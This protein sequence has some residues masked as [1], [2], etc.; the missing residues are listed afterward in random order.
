MHGLT[1]KIL[2]LYEH[3]LSYSEIAR[4]LKC[5]KPNVAQTI[6]RHREWKRDVAPIPQEHVEWIVKQAKMH[7]LSPPVFVAS[8]LVKVIN[9]ELE[10]AGDE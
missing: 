10:S 6:K 2:T 8:L 4:Q 1:V 9:K 3:G 7:R 5:S